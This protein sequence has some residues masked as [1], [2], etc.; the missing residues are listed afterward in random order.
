MK[1]CLDHS[2][3]TNEF[4]WVHFHRSLLDWIRNILLPQPNQANIEC[5]AST[6]TKEKFVIKIMVCQLHKTMVSTLVANTLRYKRKQSCG[7]NESRNCP[8]V[9]MGR[10]L[11]DANPNVS[12]PVKGLANMSHTTELETLRS[13]NSRYTL[14]SGSISITL[15]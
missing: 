4:D 9:S 6:A 1:T 2:H 14:F 15:M 3:N 5:Q 10:N 7:T 11:R 8:P 12:P 13:A